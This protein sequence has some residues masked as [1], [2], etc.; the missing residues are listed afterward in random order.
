MNIGDAESKAYAKF[1]CNLST[2]LANRLNA[3]QNANCLVID[4]V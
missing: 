3:K 4:D 1:L 2:S